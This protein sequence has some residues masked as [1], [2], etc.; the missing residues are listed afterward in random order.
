MASSVKVMKYL[1]LHLLA[2]GDGPHTSVC[3]SSPKH[4]AWGP[5]RIFGMGLQVVRANIQA[6]HCTSHESGSNLIPVIKPFST[7]AHALAGAMCPMCQWS[8]IMETV[9]TVLADLAMCMVQYRPH[10]DC[11]MRA[12]CSPP[13]VNRLRFPPPIEVW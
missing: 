10:A 5:T 9:S 7:R 2:M 1:H 8:S 13:G 3:T 12:M 11:G 4:W 6:S